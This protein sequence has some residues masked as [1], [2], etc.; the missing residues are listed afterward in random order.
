MLASPSDQPCADSLELSRFLPSVLVK[1]AVFVGCE[2]TRTILPESLYEDVISTLPRGRRCEGVRIHVQYHAVEYIRLSNTLQ[3]P[4]GTGHST[5]LS[6][7]VM[8]AKVC[9]TGYMTRQFLAPYAHLCAQA[10]R[11]AYRAVWC[12][13]KSLLKKARP[14]QRRDCVAACCSALQ[15]FAVCCSVLQCVVLRCSMLQ[16]VVRRARAQG[17]E[18]L[19]D[20]VPSLFPLDDI[21][22]L[23]GVAVCYPLLQS[24]AGCCRVSQCILPQD[25]R[26][27]HPLPMYT[28]SQIPSVPLLRPY[29]AVRA[30]ST[31]NRG[32]AEEVM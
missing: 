7:G 24:V 19:R 11:P 17:R 3:S 28:N 30:V 31:M 12:V 21:D 23:Q 13:H 20:E 18:A 6:R 1:I 8:R 9:I 2:N 14:R 10:T 25:D 4:A 27:C 22:H 16:C 15:C 26:E 29:P 32:L 5:H